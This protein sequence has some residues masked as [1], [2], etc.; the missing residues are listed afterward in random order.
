MVGAYRSAYRIASTDP[1]TP[2]GTPPT[3]GSEQGLAYRAVNREWRAMT[4]TSTQDTPRSGDTDSDVLR[5]LAEQRLSDLRDR[6]AARAEKEQAARASDDGITDDSG[7]GYGQS[8]TDRHGEGRG[9]GM[10]Y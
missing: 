6:E 9:S 7:Y 10:G 3:S 2:L 1:R 8:Y 4:M 5:H